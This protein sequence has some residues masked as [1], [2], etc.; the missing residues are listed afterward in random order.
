MHMGWLFILE[1]QSSPDRTHKLTVRISEK[2]NPQSGGHACRIVNI[3][4]N[5][6]EGP[7]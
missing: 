3:A 6:D 2:K 1:A 5:G 7:E 4:V